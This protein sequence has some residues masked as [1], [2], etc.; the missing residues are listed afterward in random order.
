MTE[1]YAHAF[2]AP[3]KLWTAIASAILVTMALTYSGCSGLPTAPSITSEPASESVS[4]LQTA[5]F[6]VSAIGGDA[7]YQWK[8]NG[9]NIPGATGPSY[10]TPRTTMADN[11]EKFSVVISN[12]VGTLASRIATLTVSP[13]IDVPTYHYE[14]MRMGQDVNEKA[15][16]P[17]TVNATNFG[18]LG[19]F[20]VDGLVDAQPLY[21]SNVIL[22]TFGPRNVLYVVTE[23]GTV[24][25]FD[26]DSAGGDMNSALWIT[27]T[28]LPGE[29]SSD[30]FGC[31]SIMPEIGIT[32]TP[33]IDR[34]LGAIYVVAM[35]KDGSGNY[36]Q[37]IHALDLT[38]GKELF[39]GP[40]TIAA[41]YPGVGANSSNGSVT[42]DPAQYVDRA[43]LIEVNGSIYTTWAS[44]CDVGA[45]TS[46]MIAY[47]ASTLQQSGVLNLVPNGERGGIWM[48]AA[49]PAADAAGNIYLI[50]GNGDFDTTLNAGGM[51][52]S[53][54]CGN[55]FVKVSS[56]APLTL[57]DYFTPL[58]TVAESEK[59]Y[60]FGSGGP[61]LLPDVTDA[62]GLTKHL[63]VGAGKDVIMYVVD[64][65]NMGK[66]NAGGNQIYQELNGAL[67]GI[68]FSSPAY[69]N[70][71]IYYGSAS[72]TIKTF[73]VEKAAIA[74]TP[75]ST[76][77]EKYVYPGATPTISADS[78]K[79][80]V[81]WTVMNGT[82]AT[83]F[84]YDATNLANELYNSNQAS[85]ARDQFAGNKFI[86]PMVANGKVY[87]GTPSS[88]VVFG[89]LP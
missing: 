26:S 85:D 19:A 35:S 24:F 49:G 82:I 86:T 8:K 87:V 39:G 72:D 59:D 14:N 25:A 62:K 80:G 76:S 28:L 17:A 13:G 79:N 81:V 70:G 5:T 32:S 61:M 89:L 6:K 75:S 52:I 1:F 78:T 57:L 46:W 51:P 84:A 45:Y 69:F 36:F 53:G 41:S 2:D 15:L 3:R 50:V 22:P 11:G 71:S 4:A 10:T 30:D 37:R 21:L 31:D 38:T 77:P 27:S 60:D 48:S 65:D 16:S 29:T 44:H 63:A 56:T 12:R 64:R 74:S 88:V 66:F 73:P 33:V 58:N 23:H 67:I 9:V 40:T 20:A 34:N 7:S 68:V 54:N 83:L 18:K 43:A 47:N 42:F 55:C